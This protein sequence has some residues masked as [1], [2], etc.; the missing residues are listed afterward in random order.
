MINSYIPDATNFEE[1]RDLIKKFIDFKKDNKI[2]YNNL[3]ISDFK[4]VIKIPLIEKDTPQPELKIEKFSLDND[5]YLTS[6]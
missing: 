4:I 1:K 5:V 6:Y 3:Y 2:F